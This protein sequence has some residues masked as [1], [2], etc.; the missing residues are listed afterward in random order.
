MIKELD[1]PELREPIG[2]LGYGIEGA[3]TV[4]YLLANGYKD[5]TVFDRKAPTHLDP[6]VRYFED[7]ADN[8]LAGIPSMRTLFRSAGVRPDLAEI[9]EFLRRGGTL[10]SQTGLAFALAGRDR[11]IGVT[12]TLGKGTCCSILQAMLSEAKIPASLGGNI[13]VPALELAASLPIG[14]KL[15]LELSSFQL[16]TLSMSPSAAAILKTTSEHLDWHLSQQE[17][18]Q[19]KANLV[20]SQNVNDIVTYHADSMGSAWIAAQSPGR[21]LPY[22]QSTEIKITDQAITWNKWAFSLNLADTRLTG[23]FNLENLAAAGTLALELGA[24]PKHLLAAAAAFSG[25]EHR[26]EFIRELKGISFYNDSYATRPDAVIGAIAAFSSIPTGLILGGSDKLADF[27]ELAQAIA[28][29][30]HIHA[31]ALIG[32]TAERLES[33]IKSTGLPKLGVPALLRAESLEKAVEFLR[34]KVEKGAIL[35]S[36]ACA[37]FGMFE[38]YKERGKAFKRLVAGL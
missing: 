28:A 35:L 24:Q 34:S 10:T 26:L 33:E 4:Q 13:G 25:L 9:Q 14:E 31:I 37:S 23:K 29:A 17:Y 12:G 1:L 16:S 7:G 30:P 5:I 22:G 15:I 6:R 32:Q 18:W 3:S 11:I 38:N 19:H 8:Y 2:V 21:K 27:S 36:P 20:A